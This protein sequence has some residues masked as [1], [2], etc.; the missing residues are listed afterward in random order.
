MPIAKLDRVV[1]RLNGDDAT[2]WLDG[3]ITNSLKDD[4][5]FAALLTPQG[6]I[7]ADFFVIKDD[8]TLLID[9]ADKFADILEKRLKMYR[10]RAKVKLERTER[11]V[12][13]A[14]D[15]IGDEG[16][17]DPR[18][19]RLGQRLYSDSLEAL[20][21]ADEYNA[22]RLSMSIPDSQWDFDT[23]ETFPANANMDQLNG[24]DFKKGCFIGQEVVS[25]MYRKTEVR[26]R[27]I[28]FTFQSTFD[29]TDI[30]RSEKTVGTIMSSYEGQG[31]AM[32][33]LD[34]LAKTDG[35]LMVNGTEIIL[36]ETDN[37]D[38]A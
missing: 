12:Y 9:V 7:I 28:G 4:I 35:P 13:A 26:K 25:R 10:L 14:W 30:T 27:M 8:N 29:G 22:Y 36:R 6:K 19:T 21:S 17:K 2:S 33:R 23:G 18:N 5:T 38:Q 15:G 32:M 37:G 24:V 20:S 1:L 3:L 16:L 11:H 31:M 34:R